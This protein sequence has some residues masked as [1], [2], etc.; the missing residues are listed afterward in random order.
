MENFFNLQC[1]SFGSLSINQRRVPAH[2][3]VCQPAGMCLSAHGR[4]RTFSHRSLSLPQ[5]LHKLNPTIP[6][7]TDQISPNRSEGKGSG[8]FFAMPAIRPSLEYKYQHREFRQKLVT[9]YGRLIPP[10][11]GPQFKPT[12]SMYYEQTDK[13]E[14]I[15]RIL[16]Q[17]RRVD[18]KVPLSSPPLFSFLY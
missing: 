7:L 5:H 4:L 14:D 12:R 11:F 6:S 8:F 1:F 16:L 15:R 2:D 10:G 13:P 3:D 9:P 18:G 17:R